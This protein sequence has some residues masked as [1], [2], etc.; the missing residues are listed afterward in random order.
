VLNSFKY[1]HSKEEP[2]LH[3][4]GR[5]GFMVALSF[6]SR[7]NNRFVKHLFF[8]NSIRLSERQI[9]TNRVRIFLGR[10]Y[11]N[12]SDAFAM[13]AIMVSMTELYGAPV[14]ERF[15][16]VVQMVNIIRRLGV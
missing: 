1:F 13:G 15:D 14:G 6:E 5:G 10:R 4:I 3:E 12:P 9:T 2:T 11:I 7:L 8:P 16:N